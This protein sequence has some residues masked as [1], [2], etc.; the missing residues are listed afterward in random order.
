MS[1]GINKSGICKSEGTS[2]SPDTKTITSLS[3]FPTSSH[4]GTHE[5]H[6]I[7]FPDLRLLTQS[8]LPVLCG[9]LSHT[10]VLSP[11][12]NWAQTLHSRIIPP[13]L[14]RHIHGGPPIMHFK[15]CDG[16][17]HL[18]PLGSEMMD[19]QLPNTVINRSTHGGKI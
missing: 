7:L 11:A 5:H 17:V 8:M 2:V 18:T 14:H 19:W 12:W 15:E 13:R 1:R 10:V 6:L 3:S 16:I 9:Q 4:L